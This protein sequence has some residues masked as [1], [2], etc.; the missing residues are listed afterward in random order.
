MLDIY[1]ESDKEA[2]SFCESLFQIN[3]KIELHWKTNEEWGNHL[4]IQVEEVD[5][6]SLDSIARALVDVFMFHRLS[7]MIRSVIK[8]VYYYTNND[9]IDKILD[10]THWIITGGD[11]EN[12]DTT[13]TEDPGLFLESLFITMIRNACTV[14]Y[15]SLVKFRIKPFKELI[16][17]FTGLAIDEV[18]REEDHQSF[19]HALREYI[20]KK[21]AVVPAVY[22][23]QGDPFIFFDANGK[24]FSNM[25]LNMIMKQEPLYIVGLD[26]NEKNLSPLIAMAPENIKIF[27]DNPVEPKT[28][29]VINVFQERVEFQPMHNFPFPKYLKKL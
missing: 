7:D 27:G 16:K 26:S 9:E 12:I 3:K 5:D 8:D 4:R 22:M 23:L 1:M 10:L 18:K 13:G 28:L 17:C 11:D 21:K 25:E 15:D 19:V 20:V 2:I 29:T 24:R 6:A 14:Y